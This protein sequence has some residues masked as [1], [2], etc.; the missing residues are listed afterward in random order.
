M[1]GSGF[2]SDDTEVVA[3]GGAEAVATGVAVV[4]SVS[5]A[6]SID[7]TADCGDVGYFLPMVF[8]ELETG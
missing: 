3:E 2:L 5:V 6:V 1:L 8:N 7:A 4:L